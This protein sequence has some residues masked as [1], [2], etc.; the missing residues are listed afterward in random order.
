MKG[1]GSSKKNKKLKNL[2]NISKEKFLNTAIKLHSQGNI[3]L[4]SK[5]YR[6]CIDND[7]HDQRVFCNLGII[8]RDLGRLRDAEIILRKLISIDPS[9]VVGYNNLSGILRELGKLTEAE[10]FLRKSLEIDPNNSNSLYNLGCLL[11]DLKKYKDAVLIFEKSLSFKQS[12]S[13]I[14]LNLGIAKRNLGD[15]KEASEIIKKAI[16]IKPNNALG[17]LN[18]GIVYR[19]LKKFK[20]AIDC[21]YKALSFNQELSSVKY[22][23]FSCKGEICDWNNF[24]D[25]QS[26]I[27][28]AG[29]SEESV[30][31]MAFFLYEDNPLS[32]LVRSKNFFDQNY[33]R[34]EV[35]INF[36]K[37]QKIRIGYFSAD[38]H[39]NHAL[40]N[41][42]PSIISLHDLS[43]FEI[44]IYSFAS[45]K[46]KCTEIYKNS[47]SVF[48]D[49]VNL[50]EEESIKVI[51]EDNLDIAVDLMGYTKKSR[52]YIFSNRVAPIQI[53]YLGYPGTM[54]S[55]KYD[56]ILGDE[57]IIPKK[58]EKFYTEKVLRLPYF[59]PPNFR[60]NE[61]LPLNQVTRE[62][63]ELPNNAF[64]FTCFNHNRKITQKEF[65]IWMRLLNEI[66]DS[67]LWLQKSNDFSDINLKKEAEK[68]NINSKRIIFARKLRSLEIHLARYSLG[69]LGLDTFFYNGHTTTSDA[70]CMGLPVLTKIGKSFSARVSSSILNSI[71][72]NEFITRNEKEYEEKALFY[73]R[74]RVEL[75]K[76]KDHLKSIKH[77]SSLSNSKE[78]TLDLEKTY[79][80]LVSKID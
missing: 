1:F 57:V 11:I 3:E 45:E 73:A 8:L 42:F 51:R 43:K 27:I 71:G 80:E 26:S 39:C 34:K 5:Y 21:Y 20:L 15:L 50:S 2:R 36:F 38:F 49:I 72:L 25:L 17:F 63:F 48:K 22:E 79:S 53:N 61:K 28:D 18:L 33:K 4:A 77:D 66:K 12:S 69:D 41:S 74:N 7:I 16:E 29:L 60:A 67:V 55:E 54:G 46:D 75:N 13:D 70:L 19:K 62:Q 47:S 30:N 31:P 37:K 78:Y 24:Q 32:T 9:S 56:Y 65:D 64:V 40:M 23:L 58:F 44:Y 6:Y 35:K 76:I 68:R 14:Y 59:F 52:T 10:D